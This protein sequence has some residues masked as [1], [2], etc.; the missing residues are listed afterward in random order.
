MPHARSAIA[1]AVAALGI[2]PSAA[3]STQP[4]TLLMHYMPWHETPEVRG[5]WGFHWTG[6]FG[7]A[8]PTQVDS[9]GRRDIWSN[10][11]PLIGTYDSA[12]PAV[13]ECQLLQ[14][15]VA[16]IDGVIADWYGLSPAADYPLIHEATEALFEACAEHGML[17]SACFEDRT[18][19]RLLD[20]GVLLPGQEEAHLASTFAWMQTNWFNAPHYVRKAGRPLLLNFGPLVVTNGSI[21]DNA[22]ATLPTRPYFYA[23]HNLWTQAN[24]DGAFTWVHWSG[25]D[26]DPE[27]AVVAQRLTAIHNGP[28]SYPNTVI[29]SVVVGFDDVYEPPQQSF[30]FLDHRNGET[31][32]VALSTALAGDWPIVQLVTWNDYGEGTM[33]EPTREFGYTFLEIVQDQR[34]AEIGSTFTF[35][36]EDLRLPARLLGLRKVGAQ[37]SVLDA[38]SEAIESGDADL[39]RSLLDRAA[40]LLLVTVPTDL[41]VDAG[42]PI[43]L[44]VG[45]SS[46]ATGAKVRWER[47]GVELVDGGTVSGA[48]SGALSLASADLSDAGEFRAV[49][50]WGDVDVAWASAIV[51]VRGPGAGQA[52]FDG[53]GFLEPND[54][55]Q[56]LGSFETAD[57]P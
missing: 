6:F 35:T 26:G 55:T 47:D 52:D 18:I 1:L 10:Y 32:D 8:D 20:D 9:T 4:S 29:P 15:K 7:E 13:L 16:G 49:V 36:A 22:L 24:A 48:T 31:V 17:F 33:F 34:R 3:A 44:M 46:T 39:A 41:A 56:Y 53:N 37:A 14:M 30:P 27:P 57:G 2:A 12:D 5:F 25:W 38:A 28:S 54:I 21:W 23:L 19:A 45:L 43:Q 40:D 50:S 11:Y 42:Q 51:A